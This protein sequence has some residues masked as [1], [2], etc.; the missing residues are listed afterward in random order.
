MSRGRYPDPAHGALSIEGT[1][2]NLGAAIASRSTSRQPRHPN[3]PPETPG[4]RVPPQ[5][6]FWER[7]GQHEPRKVPG[8]RGVLHRRHFSPTEEGTWLK[9]RSPT[10]APPPTKSQPSPSESPGSG[11]LHRRF[12]EAQADSMSRGRY[13]LPGRTSSKAHLANRGRHPAHGALSIEGTLPFIRG[14][15]SPKPTGFRTNPMGTFPPCENPVGPAKSPSAPLP[16]D[17]RPKAAVK[18]RAT[19]RRQ[20][21]PIPSSNESGNTRSTRA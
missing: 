4:S 1:S 14:P 8:S 6:D 2:S 9:G 3:P 12:L 15:P 13:P 16:H 7:S 21:W 5:R 17:H 19:T 11:Y 10:N 20:P 18:G